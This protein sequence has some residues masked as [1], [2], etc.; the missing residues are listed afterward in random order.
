MISISFIDRADWDVDAEANI[1]VLLTK[2]KNGHPSK[3]LRK[4]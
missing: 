4:I 2:F 1:P 3:T